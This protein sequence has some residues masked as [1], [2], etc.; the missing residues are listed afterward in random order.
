METISSPLAQDES[1]ALILHQTD[2]VSTFSHRASAELSPSRRAN[3]QRDS[4]AAAGGQRARRPTEPIGAR[5]DRCRA[6]SGSELD[7][8]RGSPVAREWFSPSGSRS[9]VLLTNLDTRHGAVIRG[10]LA[11]LK[12]DLLHPV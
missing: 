12:R 5:S 1:A 9:L 2:P 4:A 7:N 6:C 11:A 8:P 3:P 10:W